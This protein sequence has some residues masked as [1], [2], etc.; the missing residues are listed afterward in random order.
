VSGRPW[1]VAHQDAWPY[2]GTGASDGDTIPGIVGYETDRTDGSMPNGTVVLSN[3]PVTDV[4]GHADVQQGAIRDLPGGAFVF[5]AGTIEWSWGL[6]KQGVADP[7]VQRV[8]ENVF[9][10]ASLAPAP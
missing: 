4:F 10:R 5:A 6:S 9:R 7:R 8:T 1:I 3:S 2:D